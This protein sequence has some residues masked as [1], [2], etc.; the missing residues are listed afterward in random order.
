MNTLPV[1]AEQMPYTFKPGCPVSAAEL[2]EVAFDHLGFDGAIHEGRIVVHQVIVDPLLKALARAVDLGFPIQQAIPLDDP[3]F[4]GD[5]YASMAANN[6][7]GFNYRTIA[8]TDKVSMH[9]L[10]LA[11]DINPL[12]NPYLAAD[13]IWYPDATHIERTNRP[14]VFTADHPLTRTF[15]A[16][17]FEWGGSWSR[18][19]F[20]HFQWSAPKR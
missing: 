13:G 15:I 2:R 17:G 4:R 6:S 14:G 8:G 7:S 20:H 1:T 18:P 5:D 19:D 9:A 11:V 3:A 12:L 16:L 10:G